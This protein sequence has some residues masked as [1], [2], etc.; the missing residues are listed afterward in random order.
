MQAVELLMEVVFWHWQLIGH[1]GL[2]ARR[3]QQLRTGKKLRSQLFV[4]ELKHFMQASDGGI[5]RAYVISL[6]QISS[7]LK[8]QQ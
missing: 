7:S 5:N 6:S 4:H 1:D 2:S 8:I 3:N